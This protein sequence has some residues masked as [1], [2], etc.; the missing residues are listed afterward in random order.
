MRAT[1]VYDKI[2]ATRR[3]SGKCPECGRRTARSHTETMTVN[4]FNKNPDGSVRT[5]AEVRLAVEAKADAW[6]PDFRHEVCR[7]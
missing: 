4:P 5:P 7:A 6:V 3:R 1:Y 2:T